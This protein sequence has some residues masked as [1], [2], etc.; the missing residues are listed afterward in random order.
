LLLLLV[1]KTNHHSYGIIP[2]YKKDNEIFICCVQNIKSDE[3][4]LPKGT[5]EAGETPFETARRELEEETGISDFEI[6]G[7][8]TFSEKYSFEQ[9]GVMH[10]KQNTYYI[11]EVKEMKAKSEEKKEKD[12]DI[13]S[14]DMKWINVNEADNFF[15]FDTIKQV[16]KEVT[17][18]L[19]KFPMI[20]EYHGHSG[21]DYQFEYYESDSIEHLPKEQLAQVAVMAFHKDKLL[22]VNNSTKPG[23]YGPV[24]GGIEKDE[25]PED[26]LAR[27]LKEEA[28]MKVLEY[29][30]LGYQKCV[31]LTKPEKSPEYQIRYFAKVEPLGPFT[32]DCDP[33]GD[34]TELLEINPAEYKK[35]FDWG[36]TGEKIMNRSM[37]LMS[38]L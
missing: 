30:L 35:Y 3:W 23:M 7:G 19:N 31:N 8:K 36:E 6:I 20:T 12:P 37:E 21:E 32:P 27:E 26:C 1:M 10:Q 16:L 33:D 9:D 24:S 34:V 13:D 25:K 17:E 5:P 11:A 29:K 15:K 14:K 18:Y 2:I 28:N 22:I 4:G 38:E